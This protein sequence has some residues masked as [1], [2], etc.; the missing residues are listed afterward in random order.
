[1]HTRVEFYNLLIATTD[2]NTAC[3]YNIK[4]FARLGL[5]D[6][7]C[8]G[9]VGLEVGDIQNLHQLLVREIA[10]QRNL[11]E[12]VELEVDLGGSCFFDGF[13]ADIGHRAQQDR[14]D[15]VFAAAAVGGVD[16]HIVDLLCLCIRKHLGEVVGVVVVA[17]QAIAAEQEGVAG[18]DVEGEGVDL[19]IL[20]DTDGA[21]D[22][23]GVRRRTRLLA[24]HLAAFDHLARVA[25]V[26]AELVDLAGT[27]HVQ[28][29]V[30]D[31]AHH[32]L[33]ADDEHHHQRRSHPGFAVIG[34]RHHENLGARGVD[35]ELAQTREFLT[36]VG[37]VFAGIVD[38]RAVFADHALHGFD[39]VGGGDFAGGMTTHPVA[40]DVE[41]ERRIEEEVV[42][43]VIA[44]LADVGLAQG[45]DVHGVL[46]S[47]RRR[48]TIVVAN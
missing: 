5:F 1:M 20:L 29:R 17:V 38:Q 2:D 32:A 15:V 34:G 23:V 41:P 24:G 12:G 45:D 4:L 40:H 8:S 6:D 7:L 31:V 37:V 28:A 42:L 14:G 9:L 22:D 10:K 16:Q 47:Q 35:R 46:E 27:H 26:F 11:L 43:V 18:D 44:L 3:Q 48:P 25:V 13:V 36:G 30:A 21:G 33:A 39:G 19:D